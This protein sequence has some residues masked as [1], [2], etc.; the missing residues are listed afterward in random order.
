MNEVVLQ[1]APES[2]EYAT[3]E[4]ANTPAGGFSYA[5]YNRDPTFTMAFELTPDPPGYWVHSPEGPT[6]LALPEVMSSLMTG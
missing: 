3:T 4:P 6:P 2:S 5:I 1:L